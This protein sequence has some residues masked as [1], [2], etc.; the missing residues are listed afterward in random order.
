[1]VSVIWVSGIGCLAMRLAWRA[2]Q[3]SK[4]LRR[5]QP[6]EDPE[7]TRIVHDICRGMRLGKIPE[8][9]IW[10]SPG[11]NLAPVTVGAFRPQIVLSP[12]LF[13]SLSKERLRDAL[14]HECATSCGAD[15]FVALIQRITVIGFWPHPLVWL[16]DRGLSRA[17]EEVCDNYVLRDSDGASYAET[18]LDVCQGLEP[19]AMN[20][21]Q[22]GLFER[23]WRLEQRIAGLLDGN[24]V[25][26]TRVRPARALVVSAVL[27]SA[28]T[29]SGGVRLLIADPTAPSEPVGGNQ[30]SETTAPLA[31]TDDPATHDQDLVNELGMRSVQ[32]LEDGRINAVSLAQRKLTGDLVQQLKG[33]S[34]LN[35]LSLTPDNASDIDLALLRELPTIEMLWLDG[36]HITPV[37]VS[38]LRQL[39]KLTKLYL[40]GSSVTDSSL[41]LLSDLPQLETLGF[42]G[43]DITSTGLVNLKRLPKLK[44]VQ[45]QRF[46][47]EQT[48]PGNCIITDA[49]L[50]TLAEVPTLTAISLGVGCEVSDQ[51]M[52][53]VGNLPQ[54]EELTV[55]RG[56]ITDDGLA[57]LKS[58]SRLTKLHLSECKW[59]TDAGLKHL[60]GLTQLQELGLANGEFTDAGM[61]HLESLRNLEKLTL[62]GARISHEGLLHLRPLSNLKSLFF[63]GMAYSDAELEVLGGL[64]QLTSLFLTGN[65]ITDTGLG[66]L[67]GLTKLEDLT[68]HSSGITDDGLVSLASLPELRSL[69]I[70]DA[71][72]GDAGLAHLARSR[73]LR[74]LQIRGAS[75]SDEGVQYLA[76]LT[77]LKDLHLSGSTISDVGLATVAELPKLTSLTLF[78]TGASDTGLAHLKKL[79]RLRRLVVHQAPLIS[80]AAVEDLQKALPQCRIWYESASEVRQDRPRRIG[81]ARVPSGVAKQPPDASRAEQSAVAAQDSAGTPDRPFPPVVQ[82]KPRPASPTADAIEPGTN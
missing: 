62:V 1:M 7:I 38:H 79:S 76:S 68:V 65:E 82:P 67:K 66:Y 45:F 47:S 52:A 14:M 49:E 40:G 19:S 81:G 2:R 29:L 3:L 26:L 6:L 10:E 16:M 61:A 59:F 11:A 32:S 33:L 77:E 70:E 51:G 58:C 54:L 57:Q 15:V 9:R 13:G 30:A 24:R 12:T 31:I 36:K 20:G 18:L 22:L 37:G 34:A 5:T 53:I 17:R 4:L 41:E 46:F 64:P 28:V 43:T 69:N 50:R 75:V 80:L 25:L 44:S 48:R 42:S 73:H 35:G 71:P 21:A 39:A 8:L 63:L 55:L 74:S 60:G 72:I 56:G 78:G 27:L 23:P